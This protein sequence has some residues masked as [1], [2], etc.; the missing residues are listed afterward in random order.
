MATYLD[1]LI[2]HADVL[3]VG[4]EI[5]RRGHDGELNRPLIAKRLVCP[6]PHRADLFD[7]GDTVVRNENLRGKPESAHPNPK[8]YF[9][10][11]REFSYIGNDCVSIVRCHK[12]LDFAGR[13]YAEVVAAD[14]V[15]SKIELG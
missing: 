6:F 7:G 8:Q 1:V 15:R 12:V 11:G 2:R 4:L 10:V 9:F 14:K 13:G 5:L 3:C